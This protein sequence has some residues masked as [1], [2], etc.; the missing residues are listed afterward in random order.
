MEGK[1]LLRDLAQ[2]ER[3]LNEKL[4][5]ARHSA[6]SRISRAEEEA[7]HILADAE[8]QIHRMVSVSKA[9]VAEECESIAQES[10]KHAEAEARRIL[11]QAE[12]R[13][14]KAVEFIISKVMP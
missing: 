2:L 4:Q 3:E 6:E 13:I 11:D 1:E 7:R 8:G 10:R 14:G 9:Q 12:P 5:N